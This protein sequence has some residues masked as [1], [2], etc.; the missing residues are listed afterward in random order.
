MY[1][2]TDGKSAGNGTGMAEAEFSGEPFLKRMANNS[3]QVLDL[4]N[5]S[6]Y[7]IREDRRRPVGL[8]A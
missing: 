2:K 4:E 8:E 6:F 5:N 7:N 1:W 3:R